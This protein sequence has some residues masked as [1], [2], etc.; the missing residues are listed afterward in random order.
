MACVGPQHHKKKKKAVV[1]VAIHSPSHV[2]LVIIIY[3]GRYYESDH[4]FCQQLF[5]KIEICMQC[6][7]FTPLQHNGCC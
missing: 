7:T 3:K 4:T 2:T 1:A 6:H 5:L